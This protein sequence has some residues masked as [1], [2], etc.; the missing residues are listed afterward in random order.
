MTSRAFNRVVAVLLVT[1]LMFQTAEPWNRRTGER[2]KGLFSD[3]PVLRCSGSSSLF[4]DQALAA[5]NPWYPQ[6]LPVPTMISADEYRRTYRPRVVI[7]QQIMESLRREG[8]IENG[9]CDIVE[10]HGLAWTEPDGS[11]HLIDEKLTARAAGIVWATAWGVVSE[12]LFLNWNEIE[13]FVG[14]Q[15]LKET[16]SFH[17]S[18][19]R[20]IRQSAEWVRLFRNITG[21]IADASSVAAGLGYSATINFLGLYGK[22]VEIDNPEMP[23]HS[24][25]GVRDWIM[26]EFAVHAV[27]SF[28]TDGERGLRGYLSGVFGTDMTA[29]ESKDIKGLQCLVEDMLT[30]LGFWNDDIPPLLPPG[31]VLRDPDDRR[32]LTPPSTKVMSEDEALIQHIVSRYGLG[33]DEEKALR[34]VLNGKKPYIDRLRRAA[35]DFQRAERAFQL[36]FRPPLGLPPAEDLGED[37]PGHF[38]QGGFPTLSRI[39]SLEEIRRGRFSRKRSPSASRAG[40][41]KD[42]NPVHLLVAA[43]MV[44]DNMGILG[45]EAIAPIVRSLADESKRTD[46]RYQLVN[47]SSNPHSEVTEDRIE[48]ILDRAITMAAAVLGV[49]RDPPG[50]ESAGAGGAMGH[51]RF[52]AQPQYDA[53]QDELEIKAEHTQTGEQHVIRIKAYPVTPKYLAEIHATCSSGGLDDKIIRWMMEENRPGVIL[54]LDKNPYEIH[55]IGSYDPEYGYLVGATEEELDHGLAILHEGGHA[56]AAAGALTADQILN[57][58]R[59]RQWYRVKMA[60]PK[61]AGFEVHYALRA[62]QREIAPWRDR[63]MTLRIQGR[64]TMA[65]AERLAREAGI[66]RPG[67]LLWQFQDERDSVRRTVSRQEDGTLLEALIEKQRL[68][69]LSAAGNPAPPMNGPERSVD[70]LIAWVESGD[71]PAGWNPMAILKKLRTF[72]NSV[73]EGRLWAHLIADLAIPAQGPPQEKFLAIIPM[74]WTQ[75]PEVIGRL[76]RH[77]YEHARDPALFKV[78]KRKVFECL[79]SLIESQVTI[80][81][82]RYVPVEQLLLADYRQS[83]RY[84]RRLPLA[85]VAGIAGWE[86][87]FE[88]IPDEPDQARFRADF[89]E[90]TKGL[91]DVSLRKRLAFLKDEAEFERQEIEGVLDNLLYK[92]RGA[93]VFESLLSEAE[94]QQS[95]DADSPALRWIVRLLVIPLLAYLRSEP[96]LFQRLA[97][98]LPV[99][100]MPSEAGLLLTLTEAPVDV[101]ER[102]LGRFASRLESL[103]REILPEIPR[104]DHPEDVPLAKAKI[105]ELIHVFN[106]ITGLAWE[107]LWSPNPM[108]RELGLEAVRVLEAVA[109]DPKGHPEIFRQARSYLVGIFNRLSPQSVDKIAR[110]LGSETWWRPLLGDIVG[111]SDLLRLLRDEHVE[112]DPQKGYL[113]LRRFQDWRQILRTVMADENF[114]ARLR[115][116]AV[117]LLVARQFLSG[118]EVSD[119]GSGNGEFNYDL[120]LLRGAA[121]RIVEEFLTGDGAFPRLVDGMELRDEEVKMLVTAAWVAAGESVPVISP[122]GFGLLSCELSKGRIL[123]SLWEVDDDFLIG[124]RS[125]LT[126]DRPEALL[127]SS[128]THETGHRYLNDEARFHV[129]GLSSEMIHEFIA[130]LFAE[131]MGK[132]FGINLTAIRR[133]LNYAGKLERVQMNGGV[134]TE[135]HEGA[136]AQLQII[137]QAFRKA[138]LKPPPASELLDAGLAVLK[139]HHKGALHFADFVTEMLCGYLNI[140][141]SKSSPDSPAEAEIPRDI[142]RVDELDP[143]FRQPLLMVEEIGS[144]VSKATKTGDPEGLVVLPSRRVKR[145]A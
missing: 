90:R 56:M 118:V 94:R 110:T 35:G 33:P 122:M 70:D 116:Y 58:V 36:C 85:R 78:E 131:S 29:E 107:A 74:L 97:D 84:E 12:K 38:L 54:D 30:F 27:T 7:W 10:K 145:Y 39:K 104:P 6:P 115:L 114:N 43:R 45:P 72:P 102:L 105:L 25:T 120:D 26:E 123:E 111:I 143:E 1:A 31:V 81:P 109:F 142:F 11:S 112:A 19:H 69:E 17:E 71:I 14:I 66:R 128:L 42:C 49:K 86:K 80:D 106:G 13:N 130:D 60:D 53:D 141:V 24:D 126:T 108:H 57:Y 103:S 44:R 50:R 83:F 99:E 62:W 136:R 5:I 40:G 23:L 140:S 75:N 28:S 73:V 144:L 138:G 92:D 68:R 127:I 139:A 32:D 119:Y 77:L 51:Y 61:N 124:T 22:P 135:P 93:V 47:Q 8:F 125:F 20:M 87:Y 15:W 52:L 64:V 91:R 95:A 129:R 63:E 65:E 89:E 121:G 37:D 117:H 41:M 67:A 21:R 34:N 96:A 137:R 2:V 79:N 98:V 55:G 9:E 18:I 133:Y 16:A 3:A 134:S 132:G 4:D 88:I 46:V 59:D 82:E 48:F 76:I 101:R 113:I 100:S